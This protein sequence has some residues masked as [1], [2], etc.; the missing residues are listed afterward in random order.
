MSNAAL[1]AV[2]EHSRTR[3]GP[4]LLLLAL[5]DRA[6][7]TGRC[8]PGIEDLMRR[9]GLSKTGVY[10]ATKQAKKLGRSLNL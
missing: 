4:R 2:F 5:A 8:W 10:T 6:N 7:D 1:T 9:T 3:N